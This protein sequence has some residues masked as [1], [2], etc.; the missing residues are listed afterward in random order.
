MKTNTNPLL[1]PLW[2]EKSLEKSTYPELKN[3]LETDVCI[4][5]GGIA[6]LSIAYQLLSVGKKVV[7]LESK[8][9]GQGETGR[10][11]AHLMSALDDRYYKIEKIHGRKK[12][13]L[14]A[15][16][17]IEAINWIESVIEKEKIDCNF[18]RLCGFLFTRNTN[19]QELTKEFEAARRFGLEVN[20]ADN[21]KLGR[22]LIFAGQ[23]RFNPKQY[24]QGLAQAVSRMGGKIYENSTV[25]S[26]DFKNSE[27]IL[28]NQTKVKAKNI[29]TAVNAPTFG[30]FSTLFK[31]NPQRTYVIGLKIP[32]NAIEDALYWDTDNPYHYVRL[33]EY[34]ENFD[35]LIVGGEDHRVGVMPQ[36]NPFLNL[37][38]W[39]EEVFG[40]K[41]LQIVYQW[42]G[43][44]LEPVDALAYIGRNPKAKNAF[45]VTGDSGNGITH[46]TLA[47]QLI[48]DL[49]LT[50][51]SQ[52][53]DV[54]KVQRLPMRAMKDLLINM[55]S[56]MLGYCKYLIP[57]WG[58][59]PAAGEG[60]IL[61]RGFKKIAVYRD[62]DKQIKKCSGI[63]NH[64]GGILTWNAI[65]KTWDCPAHGS[66]F[67]VEGNFLNGPA[68][69]ELECP[70]K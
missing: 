37:R 51:H 56:S 12:A 66:R 44:I 43:Q 33:E 11:N 7:L 34:N 28:S 9:I 55:G 15:K 6:G 50:G 42:S 22:S 32:K 64:M 67:D 59:M 39:T 3:N 58:K 63:C 2:N 48:A 23:G 36:Q 61:Q 5:G 1:Q 45:M 40:L 31:V 47:A 35:I 49:I 30:S 25:N 24:L 17:H 68:K 18:K 10:S 41:D 20:Y 26:V 13:E 65:D 29:V 69:Q 46:G 21:V 38:R 8:R 62:A 19:N 60:K 52:Y 57:Q 70:L 4:A 53:E 14:A 27:V 16:S 54:Y